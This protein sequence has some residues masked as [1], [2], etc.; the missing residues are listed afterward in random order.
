MRITRKPP[1]RR[2]GTLR[3]PPA[4]LQKAFPQHFG[5]AS[6]RGSAR[7]AVPGARSRERDL[8]TSARDKKEKPRAEARQVTHRRQ[9]AYAPET[10]S[11]SR[12]RK[13]PSRPALASSSS[14][15]TRLMSRWYQLAAAILRSSETPAVL[16]PRPSPASGLSGRRWP[17]AGPRGR[18]AK[19]K[20]GVAWGDRPP[21]TRVSCWLEV[22]VGDVLPPR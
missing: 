22:P 17:S 14:A 13:Q 2:A 12:T 11:L 8:G 6:P 5:S 1:Y 4:S 15:T 10:D 18:L 7:I 9:R 16:R 20:V 19:V 21:S 3:T